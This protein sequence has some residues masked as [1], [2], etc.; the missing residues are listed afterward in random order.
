M[1]YESTTTATAVGLHVIFT[2]PEPMNILWQYNRIEFSKLLMQA[3]R[4]PA[5]WHCR[6]CILRV[7]LALPVPMRV[8]SR[9]SVG[10]PWINGKSGSCC[11][12]GSFK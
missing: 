5:G 3:A 4:E 11:L 7:P 8:Q 10:E 9:A 2:V 6:T 1:V 12:G